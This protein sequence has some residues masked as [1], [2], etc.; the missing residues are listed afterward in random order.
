[1]F[2]TAV[3]L[4]YICNHVTVTAMLLFALQDGQIYRKE[5]H[6]TYKKAMVKCKLVTTESTTL[7]C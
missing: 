6:E 3:P 1:M 7:Y 5:K 4:P 2:L